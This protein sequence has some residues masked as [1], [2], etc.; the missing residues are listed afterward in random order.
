MSV[1]SD[2]QAAA[3]Q[4]ARSGVLATIGAAGQPRTVPI[5]FVLVASGNAGDTDSGAE[6]AVIQTPIDEKPKRGADPLALARVRD[7]Q[8]NPSVSVLIERWDEDWTRLGWL[9]MEGRAEVAEADAEAVAALRAKYPQYIDH[10]LEDRPMIRIVI[11]RVRA[12][13]TLAGD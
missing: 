4:A 2:P 11:D 5:C 13:G 1:L 10:R 7:I 6:P 12:W 9:R 3:V 8:A